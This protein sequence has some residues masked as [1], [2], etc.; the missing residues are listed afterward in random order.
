M[1]VI[2]KD[3]IHDPVDKSPRTQKN[4]R[5]LRAACQFAVGILIAALVVRTWLVMGLIVPMTVSGSS[6]APA[7][8]GP[9]RVYHCTECDLEFRLGL[10]DASAGS[11]GVCPHC[12]KWSAV[13]TSDDLPGDR[14]LVDRMA[15]ALREPRRWEV[16][17]FRSPVDANKLSVKRIAGLPGETVALADGNVLINGVRIPP[18][19]HGRYD[20]RYGDKTNSPEGW[21]LGSHEY[22]VVGDNATISDDSRNWPNGPGLDDK[23]LVGKVLGS[24]R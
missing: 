22:F 19:H 17:V 8:L 18:P 14:L 7:L 10:E 23:L 1:P 4:A 5:M 21:R 6:M 15:F 9:H 16:V 13:A 20:S 11:I 2:T 12:R 24:T 3:T